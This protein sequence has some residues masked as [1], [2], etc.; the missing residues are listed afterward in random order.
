MLTYSWRA[1][2]CIQCTQCILYTVYSAQTVRQHCFKRGTFFFYFNFTFFK[3]CI[4]CLIQ[5]N[6]GKTHL[7]LLW[8]HI[9][10]ANFQGGR[11][12]FY[13]PKHSASSKDEGRSTWENM[14]LLNSFLYYFVRG[15]DDC[16][17]L[18]GDFSADTIQD[19]CMGN[20]THFWELIS[21]ITYII[22]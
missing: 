14:T 19:Q 16:L 7:N 21:L 18:D 22:L 15:R 12:L 1:V 8:K 4:C 11:G 2:H 6:L 5:Y 13:L 3:I 10:T 9:E 20:G 17:Q